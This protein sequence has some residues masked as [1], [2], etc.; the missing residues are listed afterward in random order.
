MIA[1]EGVTPG[2]V[3]AS[4]PSCRTRNVYVVGRLIAV[5]SQVPTSLVQALPGMKRNF[6]VHDESRAETSIS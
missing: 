6:A 5:S 3:G 1:K 4:V 2:A